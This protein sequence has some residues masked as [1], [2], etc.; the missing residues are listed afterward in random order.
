MAKQ[1]Q[2]RNKLENWIIL[3]EK[4][5]KQKTSIDENQQKTNGQLNLTF[6]TKE[7]RNYGQL[8][9]NV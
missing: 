9:F 6:F 4:L 3:L 2:S 8:N 5:R 1:T 7:R